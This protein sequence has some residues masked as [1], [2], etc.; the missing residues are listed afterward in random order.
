MVDFHRPGHICEYFTL[1]LWT[2]NFFTIYMLLRTVLSSNNIQIFYGFLVG[3][4][5]WL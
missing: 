1:E 4:A 3:I 5:I 2:N